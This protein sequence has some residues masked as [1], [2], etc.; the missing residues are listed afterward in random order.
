MD[1]VDVARSAPISAIR[2]GAGENATKDA[3][4][5]MKKDADRKIAKSLR[6]QDSDADVDADGDVD[7]D[8]DDDVDDNDEIVDWLF[9]IFSSFPLT[10]LYADP[11]FIILSFVDPPLRKIGVV[12]GILLNCE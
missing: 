1:K 6:V 8:N 5:T 2:T 3:D 9:E 12:V 4:R 10:L 7:V 11:L